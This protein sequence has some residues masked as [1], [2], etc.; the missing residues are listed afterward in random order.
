MFENILLLI[1]IIS[2]KLKFL[3]LIF[4]QFIYLNLCLIKPKTKLTF[5]FGFYNTN[6][7]YLIIMFYKS[8]ILL[9][10]VNR[11]TFL[12]NYQKNS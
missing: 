12:Q 4:W 2:L 3:N 11:F 8:I 10:K 7:T 9:F 6:K 5:S 1:Q